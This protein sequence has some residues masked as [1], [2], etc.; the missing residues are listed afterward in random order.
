VIHFDEMACLLYLDGQLD[1]A[2]SQELAA[3]V[4]ECPSCRELLVALQRETTLLSS[5]LTEESESIPARLL[6]ER[7]RHLP[8][9]AWT[10][11]FGV[12]AAGIY[13]LWID[14]IGPLFDQLSNAGFGG[15]D[16]FSM[17]VFSGAF[18]EGWSDIM[19]AIQIGALILV[20]IVAIGWLRHRLRRPVAVVVVVAALLLAIALPQSASA[21]DV[22][23][24]RSILIPTGEVVHNDLVVAGPSVRI[25]GVVEGDVIAFTRSLTVTGH[26]TGDVIAF[27]GNAIIDGVVD[28]NVRVFSRSVNLQGA[29]GKNVSAFTNSLEFASKG[30]VGGG[31][32]VLA[33]DVD[34]DGKIQRD[35]MG[36]IGRADLEGLVGGEVWIRGGS[37]EVASTAEIRGPATFEGPQQPV[38]ETGAKLASPIRTEITQEM[39]RRRGTEVRTVGHAILSYVALLGVGILLLLIFPGFFRATI[40]ATGGIGLPI[41][42]GALALITGAFLLVLGVLLLF[43]G[44]GAG[45]ASVMAYAPILYVAHVFVGMWLGNRIRGESSD[46]TGAI[47][48]RMAL[49]LLILRLVEL[50]PV[51]GWLVWLAVIL[52]GTGAVLMGFYRMSQSQSAPIPA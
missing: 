5:A 13:W 23:R 32:I 2:R 39:R 51:A 34:L 52:W 46:N 17:I 50:I 18:W 41:G 47:I 14:G 6:G 16:L 9:W 24:G 1:A 12:L 22:R 48:G 10:L 33:A 44:V 45:V 40:R 28:G 30:N 20:A 31:A 43:V 7:T 26:V 21:A 15:T 37:L 29:I 42:I 25:D 38:V 4:D 11:A 36:L 8:V 19:D 27:A 49:G 35:L 3:H